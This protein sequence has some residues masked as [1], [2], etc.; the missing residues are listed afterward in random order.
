MAV[1][2]SLDSLLSLMCRYCCRSL[3]HRCAAA[4]PCCRRYTGYLVVCDPQNHYVPGSRTGWWWAGAV[5]V[6]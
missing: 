5:V 3:L 4:A 1:F 6:P 2:R